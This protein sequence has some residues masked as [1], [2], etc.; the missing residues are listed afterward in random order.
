M[1]VMLSKHIPQKLFHSHVGNSSQTFLK[2][3]LE[4]VKRDKSKRKFQHQLFYNW[5]NEIERFNCF[6]SLSVRVI[7]E[8]AIHS[9][10]KQISAQLFVFSLL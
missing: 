7:D 5:L 1:T 3:N 8:R 9:H 4:V 6:G 10:A 2:P